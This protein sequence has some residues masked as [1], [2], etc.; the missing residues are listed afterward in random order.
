[1]LNKVRIDNNKITVIKIYIIMNHLSYVGCKQ[2]FSHHVKNL[3]TYHYKF[4]RKVWKE[5][6]VIVSNSDLD[7]DFNEWNKIQ[8]SLCILKYNFM[9]F[10]GT[11]NTHIT[12]SLM[13]SQSLEWREELV[14]L[15]IKLYNILIML[16]LENTTSQLLKDYNLQN[17]NFIRVIWFSLLILLLK[18]LSQIYAILRQNH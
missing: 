6:C 5:K 14:L 18:Y 11:I 12:S 13:Y 1:M 4:N 15:D 7:F 2:I 8:P 17:R 10:N 16:M 3:L 9:T